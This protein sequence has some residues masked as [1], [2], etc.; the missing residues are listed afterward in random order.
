M[1]HALKA[2]LSGS[3]GRTVGELLSKDEVWATKR[4]IDRLLSTGRHPVPHGDWPPVPWP[5][6]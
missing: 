5:P 6:F 4:R 2:E 1:L 3:L